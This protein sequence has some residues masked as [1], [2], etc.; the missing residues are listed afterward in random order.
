MAN[1]NLV[2][3]VTRK[4]DAL[5]RLAKVGI[6]SFTCF[7]VLPS[8]W[9]SMLE[10]VALLVERDDELRSSLSQLLQQW[11]WAVAAVRDLGLARKYLLDPVVNVM[12]LNGAHAPIRQR[13]VLQMCAEQR[14]D[15]MIILYGQRRITDLPSLTAM[16][17]IDQPLP[18]AHLQQALAHVRALASQ[19]QLAQP[20]VTVVESSS[21]LATPDDQAF[22]FDP[23]LRCLTIAERVIPLSCGEVEMLSHLAQQP[24][25]VLSYEE[26]AY[27]LYRV[28]LTRRE[29]RDLVKSRLY[30]LRQKIETDPRD[31]KIVRVV[32]G[33]GCV[34]DVPLLVQAPVEE[35]PAEQSAPD[36]AD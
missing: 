10:G 13:R 4:N 21:A 9:K 6:L 28:D 32:W 27:R 20:A 35:Q 25:K 36:R 12:I 16:T 5:H 3:F 2:L 30:Y 24:G 15:L 26:L 22:I 19:A 17:W 34:L 14:P 8:R 18:P 23:Q 29:A 31:P 11:R 7:L 33:R 1:R